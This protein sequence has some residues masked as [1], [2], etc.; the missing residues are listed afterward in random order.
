[1]TASDY[2]DLGS[3][4]TC[5]DANYLRHGLACFYLVEE[6]GEY[7]VIETGTCHSVP[8]LLD[9]LEDRDIAPGQVR[10]VVPTH[11]HLDHAGGAGLMMQHFPHARL[12]VHPRGAR[13]MVD[14][15]RLV[16][17]AMNVY[18]E[19]LYRELYGDIRPVDAR[20]VRQ[21]EDGETVSLAGRPL[22]FRHT[23][24]H[25]EHHFCVWD[26]ASRGWFSGDMFGVSYRWCRLPGGDFV[27]PSTTPNQFDPAAYRDSLDLLCGYA[28][29]RLYLA[30]YGELAYSAAKADLLR[31]Q[32]HDYC[33]I[34]GRHAHD[35]AGL[36][37]RLGL[38]SVALMRRFDQA[39]DGQAWRDALAFDMRLNAQ[40]LL[41]WQSTLP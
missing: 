8:R 14:P 28:P 3:G 7:A 22:Q 5:I 29:E 10:Y 27:L 37:Q 21:V 26:E 25:A 40:G 39:G 11:V 32:I 36:E 24:G 34:A 17:S 38:Y 41:A 33:E 6:G 23:R 18:G 19:A 15:Q 13:H 9:L 20:R 16:K 12:L 35:P 2:Q 31:A 4:I 30:H 1:M